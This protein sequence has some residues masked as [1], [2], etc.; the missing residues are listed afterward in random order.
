[1]S[2]ELSWRDGV[3]VLTLNRPKA[4]NALNTALLGEFAERLDEVAKAPAGQARALLIVGSGEKAFCVGADVSEL[5]GKQAEQQR[6]TARRGQLAFARLDNLRIPSVA[7]IHGVAFGGGL[8]LAMACT[9]RIAMPAA[10]MGLLEIKLGLIP[11][12]GGTQRLPRLVGAGRAVELIATGR[13]ID[14]Q[15][16]ERIGLVHRA[17]DPADP[18]EAGLAYLKA[19]GEPF[20]ASLSHALEAVRCSQSMGLQEG[21]EQEAAFFCCDPDPGCR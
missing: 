19:L 5:Q 17:V 7:V 9:F 14:A 16:A 11:G 12:F 3:A 21:L 1:M 10:R 18:V 20:P 13:A 4:L 8:E 6:E 15:E 2:A